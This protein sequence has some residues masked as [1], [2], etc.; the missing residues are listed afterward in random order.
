MPNNLTGDALKKYRQLLTCRSWLEGR[1]FDE[2]YNYAKARGFTLD[3]AYA[4]LQRGNLPR[5]PKGWV[6][7]DQRTVNL[8]GPMVRVGPRVTNIAPTPTPTAANPVVDLGALLAK[9]KKFSDVEP[10]TLRGDARTAPS[11][12]TAPE[13]ERP[14]APVT[15]Q[16]SV[17]IEVTPGFWEKPKIIAE[18]VNGWPVES[19]ALIWNTCRNKNLLVIQLPDGRLAS[20][21]RDS[22]RNWRIGATI[23]VKLESAKA[24]P[25][26]SYA[27][28]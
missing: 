21:Y 28:T 12:A 22:R 25:I 27:T 16:R 19:E 6:P 10:T 26:Y 18:A 14:T 2:A 20:V 8:P 13:P 4:S 24:D 15:E 5:P 3:E 23:K 11:P 17:T 9:V 7:P 1:R